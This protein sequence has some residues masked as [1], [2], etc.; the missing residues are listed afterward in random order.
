MLAQTWV[1][2]A[3]QLVFPFFFSASSFKK[4]SFYYSTKKW[5]K[6]T[7]KENALNKTQALTKNMNKNIWALSTLNQLIR[8]SYTEIKFSKK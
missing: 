3:V 6:D 7:N 8:G 2:S 1:W 4:I 5:F